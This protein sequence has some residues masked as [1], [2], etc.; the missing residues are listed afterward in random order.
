ML[1]LIPADVGR[2]IGHIKPNIDCPD[3][4]ALTLRVIDTV[5]PTE[6]EVHDSQGHAYSL[7]IRP[8][9]NTENRI[10][11]AVLALFEVAPYDERLVRRVRE[12]VAATAALV[13]Q[14]LAVLDDALHVHWANQRF[15]Q[16]LGL[17]LERRI[18]G[19][20]LEELANGR[21]DARVLRERL[22]QMLRDEAPLDGFDLAAEAADGGSR[23]LVL[24]GRRIA[25]AAGGAVIV[26]AIDDG[27]SEPRPAG[28]EGR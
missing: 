4:E 24:S 12:S 26:L 22:E 15:R 17:P 16:L 7:R 11:G 23:N 6:R 5:T 14:P 21:W 25:A 28:K 8:Y 18:E 13:K 19:H 2:P 27:G 10:E 20:A 3:L 1:N 9:K